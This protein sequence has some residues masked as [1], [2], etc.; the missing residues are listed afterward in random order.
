M[1]SRF[2]SYTAGGRI[3]TPPTVYRGLALFGSAD[4][5]VYCLRAAD[6]TLVWRLPCRAPRFAH[7]QLTSRLES[8]V[9]RAWKR[10]GPP[11]GAA[12]FAAGRSSF[13]DGGI[14]VYAVQ[15]ATGELLRDESH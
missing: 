10:A 3:D 2:G 7:R 11:N 13:L 12:Y 4:G 8:P 9:A 14:Y 15:P 5:W 6:G 1:E